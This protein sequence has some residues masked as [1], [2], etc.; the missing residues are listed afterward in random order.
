MAAIDGDR[1][2]LMTAQLG[3]WYAQQLNPGDP[4]YNM[5]GYLD[6]RGDLDVDLFELALRGTMAEAEAAHLRFE[7]TAG[8]PR[9]HLARSGDWPLPVIDLSAAA[10]PRAA[11]AAWMRADMHR[12]ADLASGPLFTMALLRMAPDRFWWY[13]RGHHIALDAYSGSIIAAR[14]A[15]VY[16]AL[17][18]GADPAAGALAPFTAL[19]DADAAYRASAAFGRDRDFWAGVLAGRPEVTSLSGQ[20]MRAPRRFPDRYAE[21]LGPAAAA[22]LRAAA[23]DLKTSVAGLMVTAAAVFQHR[24]TEPATWSW[25]CPCS[26]GPGTAP[27]ASQA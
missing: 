7:A 17:T 14:Q 21:P 15:Q 13:Q 11:A 3:I 22:R 20:R 12:P 18:A 10:D 9:Q 16:T 24:G 27:A 2:E 25:A 23:R 26:A 5:G 4:V 19:L 1:R 8:R 6:I